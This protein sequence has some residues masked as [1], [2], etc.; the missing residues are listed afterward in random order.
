MKPPAYYRNKEQTYLKHFFLEQYLEAV[1]FHIGY[2]QREFVYVDC[3]SGP[4]RSADE[5]FAD[6]SIRIALDRLNYVREALAKQARNV[7]IRAVFIEKSPRAFTA[8]ERALKQHSRAVKTTAFLGAFVD[9]IPRILREVGSAF[10]FFFID[11]RGWTGFAMDE[12]RPILRHKPGEAMVNFMYDFVN[13][14]LNFPN[15]ANEKSLDRLFG[16]TRWREIRD[17]PDRETASVGLYIEQIRATGAFTYVTSTRILKPLHDRAY[18]HLIYATRNPKGILKF[19][20]VEKRVFTEQESVRATAQREARETRTGQTE[21]AFAAT[22][23]FSPSRQAER[24]YQL[25]KAQEKIRELAMQGPLAYETLQPL[26]L[27]LPLVWNTDLN[28]MLMDGYRN[29]QIEIQGLVPR[30]RAPKHGNIIR[31]P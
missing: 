7:K 9:T 13:R 21:M 27:Q 20:D 26:I 6:T 31:L 23:E 10:A 12:I 5:D 15:D 2:A 18:F 30:Q 3:F 25:R 22:G 8:L 28:K 14:F 11:P 4:W 29:G 24:A 17:A 16:T 19:R 1:T